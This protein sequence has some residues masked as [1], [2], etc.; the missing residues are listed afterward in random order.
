MSDE[1]I[2]A[3]LSTL[4]A[5]IVAALGIISHDV[6]KVKKDAATSRAQT[7]NDHDINLRDD[8]DQKHAAIM[9]RF[10]TQDATLKTH[11][12][13]LKSHGRS[14][15]TQSEALTGLQQSDRNQWS[16]IERIRVRMQKRRW[17]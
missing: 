8:I 14:L 13:S 2:I 9:A 6:K 3:L 10:E 12:E 17:L 5:V 11:T 7:Q 16:A 4:S 15:S 1:V